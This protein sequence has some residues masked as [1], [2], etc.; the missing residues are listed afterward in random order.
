MP[1]ST[2]TLFA[3]FETLRK[4]T[5]PSG[6]IARRSLTVKQRG[7]PKK[8]FSRSFWGLVDA[9]L[10]LYCSSWHSLLFLYTFWRKFIIISI[11]ISLILAHHHKKSSLIFHTRSEMYYLAIKCILYKSLLVRGTNSLFINCCEKMRNYQNYPF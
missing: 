6:S 10:P 3:I 9:S 2:L 4:E 11:S 1:D 5:D 8:A 7:L